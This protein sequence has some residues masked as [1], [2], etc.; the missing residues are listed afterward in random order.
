M[1]TNSSFMKAIGHV[2]NSNI[3]SFFLF[4]KFCSWWWFI[5][6]PV[7]SDAGNWLLAWYVLLKFFLASYQCKSKIWMKKVCQ[8][9][10]LRS[11]KGPSE[12]YRNQRHPFHPLFKKRRSEFVLKCL[13]FFTEYIAKGRIRFWFPINKEKWW[14]ILLVPKICK[15]A[16]VSYLTCL[17][18]GNANTSLR[19]ISPCIISLKFE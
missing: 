5:T 18:I 11:S 8:Q 16:L 12:H 14:W 17:A 19:A 1:Y 9:E 4:R 10:R 13:M 15:V 3:L 6:P 7:A 2:E